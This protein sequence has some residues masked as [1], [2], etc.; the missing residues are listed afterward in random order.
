MYDALF[1]ILSGEKSLLD[2]PKKGDQGLRQRVYRTLRSDIHDLKEVHDPIVGQQKK[3]MV[4][5]KNNCFVVKR[6]EVSQ[7]VNSAYH[8]TK[9]EGAKKLNIQ[10]SHTYCGLLRRIIQRNLNSTKRQQKVRPLFIIRRLSDQSK[11]P[12]YN[13]GIKWIL[14]V[15]LACQAI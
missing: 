12:K 9:G 7:L 4:E 14:L 2:W 8:E 5:K 11:H 15:W 3:R 13:K 10:M 1:S 6:S